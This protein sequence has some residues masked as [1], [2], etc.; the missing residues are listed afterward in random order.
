VVAQ[1]S[2]SPQIQLQ[3]TRIVCSSYPWPEACLKTGKLEN[4][5]FQQQKQ[6]KTLLLCIKIYGHYYNTFGITHEKTGRKLLKENCRAR[7]EYV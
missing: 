2:V 4:Y 1:S 3:G 5:Y 7:S 6:K